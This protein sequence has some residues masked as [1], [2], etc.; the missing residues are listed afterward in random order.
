MS[1][2]EAVLLL[3]IISVLLGRNSG[4]GRV[5]YNDP[6]TTN[7]PAYFLVPAGS[8]D[9]DPFL[10]GADDSRRINLL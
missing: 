6:P 1:S 10:E 2:F 3:I 8:H 4:R 9:T 7:P 5:H